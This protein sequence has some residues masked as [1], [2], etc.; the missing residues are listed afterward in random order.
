MRPL[1]DVVRHVLDNVEPEITVEELKFLAAAYQRIS[2]ESKI[3]EAP[4]PLFDK[5]DLAPASER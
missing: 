4:I 2:S 3:G 1:P 5:S